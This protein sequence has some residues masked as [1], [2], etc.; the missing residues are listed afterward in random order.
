MTPARPL[1]SQRTG[2]IAWMA[3]NPV[4]ANLL[5]VLFVVGGIVLGGRVKQEVF[6]EFTIDMVSV[7]VAYPGASPEEVEQ[8]IVLAIEDAVSGLDSVKRVTSTSGEG[9]GAVN[10]ELL[11]GAD[12]A[13]AQQDVQSAVD[14]IVSFPV[15]AERPRIQLIS[16]KNRVVSLAVS[17]EFDEQVIRDRAEHMRDSLLADSGITQVELKF[18]RPLEIAIEIPD[19]G[20]RTYGLTL[21][22]VA[23]AIRQGATELPAGSIRT[24]GGEVLLRTTERRDYASEFEGLPLIT[25]ADGTTVTLGQVADIREGFRDIDLAAWV[26][27][28]PAALVEVFRVGN[29]TPISVSQATREWLSAYQSQL[30]PGMDI[31]IWNDDSEIYQERIDLLL[32]NAFIG[33]ALVLLLLGLFLEPRL[34]FWVM[35]GI[36][37]SILGSFLFLP[38]SGASINMISLFAFLITLGIIV[39]D[40]VVVGENIYEKRQEGMSTL[41]AAIMGTREIAGPVFFAVMTNMIAFLPMFFVPGG[42][43][44]LFMQIPAVTIAVFFVSLVESIFVLPAHLAH[45]GADTAFWRIVSYP[46]QVFGKG[47]QWFIQRV[48]RPSVYAAAV[49]RWVTVAIGL[50]MLVMASG[51]VAGGHI[52]FTFMPDIDAGVVTARL[53]LPVGVP[54][55]EA[56][57]VRE[58]LMDAA[59]RVIADLGDGSSVPGHIS[60]IGAALSAFGPHGGGGSGGGTSIVSAMLEVEAGSEITSNEF[61]RRWRQEV[62]PIAGVESFVLD[63]RIGGGD[64]ALDVQL[65]H[66][67]R[68]ML[69][70]AAADVANMVLG[71]QGTKN[72]DSGVATGKTQ[73]DFT[74]TP[75]AKAYGLTAA[76]VASQMRHAFYGAEVLRQQRGRNEV[77]VMVRLPEAERRTLDTIEHLMLRT[78]SGGEVPFG[79]AVN[80]KTGRAYTAISRREGRR[81]VSV[82]ADID[83]AVGNA[84]QIA[85]DLEKRLPEALSKK[86]P[87]LTWSFEGEQRD[88]RDT[89][90][91]LGVGYMMAMLGIFALLAIPFKSY[92]QPLV[93]MAAI[94]FGIIGA[95]IGHVM[96]GYGLSIISMFGIIA[97]SGVVVNDSLVLVV[98]AN[99]HRDKNPSQPV[100]DAVCAAGIRR[101]RPIL[102]TS[103]T[104][105]FGLAPM[106]FES[107]MQAR[108]L[109]PMAISIGFGVLFATFIILLLVPALYLIVEDCR[110]AFRLIFQPDG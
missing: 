90:G 52:G 10:V 38:M 3:R 33:L 97:L 71:Y 101:F 8:G 6:P 14:G 51:Y 72:I 100:L 76:G 11:L 77:R 36:P 102:L 103:V 5:M 23:R 70:S 48:Y 68:G 15:D 24:Q 46:S 67:D 49:H 65:T 22:A 28:K 66:I 108:F 75:E 78:P 53:R 86:Y 62:G 45:E 93:V 80:I 60:T 92:L 110:R 16:T 79:E 109:V 19:E 63:S 25:R 20:L 29:E 87:G 57:R 69:D 44:K 35:L 81:V 59:D 32:R 41:D 64:S 105:F 73:L 37:I 42:E 43:G 106:I 31:G 83:D 95:V 98:T 2:A 91:Q 30:P 84:N 89:F 21:D 12:H 27:G 61:S 4:A 39:D 7:S 40:A 94:P 47:L 9:F 54:R 82:T 58:Q 74:L 55:A 18:I 96:L 99:M 34:A 50:A 1:P 17:G 88:Q 104:T 85:A 26:N 107:S 13:R 56:E